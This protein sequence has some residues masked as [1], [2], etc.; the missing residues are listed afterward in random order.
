MPRIIQIRA[1]G[2]GVIPGDDGS[3]P[4]KQVFLLRVFSFPR[5]R[6]APEPVARYGK[7][8]FLHQ[9]VT[10]RMNGVQGQVTGSKGSYLSGGSP[11]VEQFR[12]VFSFIR[13]VQSG[14][15]EGIGK[16]GLNHRGR[17]DFSLNDDSQPVMSQPHG[18][19]S[20]FHGPPSRR[21]QGD[22]KMPR[23]ARI[24]ACTFHLRFRNDGFVFQKQPFPMH[25]SVAVPEFIHIRRV[26]FRNRFPFPVQLQAVRMHHPDGNGGNG[27][28]SRLRTGGKREPEGGNEQ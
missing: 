6:A 19:C 9:P 1:C 15:D 13:L 26:S 28:R 22:V 24:D 3:V 7:R 20:R 8:P 4:Q 11:A 5:A 2:P 16:N 17:I 12:Q 23:R 25:F 18:G 14:D 27:R 21:V 10:V